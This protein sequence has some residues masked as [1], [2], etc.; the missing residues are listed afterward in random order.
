MKVL[1]VGSG[2]REHAL[3]D[4]LVKNAD[5]VIVVPGNGG[6]EAA[7]KLEYSGVVEVSDL[8]PREIKADLTIIGPEGPLASGLGDKLRADGRRVFGPNQDGAMLESSKAFMKEFLNELYIP[9]ASYGIFDDLKSAK[10]FLKTLNGGYVIKTDGLAQGKGVFVTRNIDEAVEDIESKLSGTAFGDAGRKVVI[11]E[12]MEGKELSVLALC[13]GKKIA[14]LSSA[15]DAKRVYDGDAGPNT[16]GMGS[17]SPVPDVDGKLLDSIVEKLIEPVLMGFK[18]RAIDYRGVLYAGIMLTEYGPKIVE[19][20]VRFGD[21]EIQSILPRLDCDLVSLM[22]QCA[23]GSLRSEPKFRNEFSV[24]VVMASKGYPQ[25]SSYGD[26]IEGI[27]NAKNLEGVK[28]FHAGTSI[29]SAGQFITSG[30]RVLSVT[31]LGSD[32][33]RARLRAYEA[34]DKIGFDGEHHRHDI[35][36]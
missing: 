6:I 19:Y 23:S 13:D 33:N 24:T 16:G 25:S 20:N 34:V 32:L 8:D 14:P 30:G 4:S 3:V 21:P 22:D 28:V 35:A 10:E 17:F 29:N 15:R 1:V 9:T 11:E 12:M 26:V 5:K 7:S 31:A 27:E 18:K 2:A 36:L